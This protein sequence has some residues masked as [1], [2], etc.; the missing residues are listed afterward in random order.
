MLMFNRMMIRQK[1][2]AG[3]G[4]VLL[5]MA[6]VSTVVYLSISSISDASRWVNHTYDVIRNADSVNAAMVDMETG[7][8]GFMITGKDEYLEPYNSGKARFNELISK[9]KQL[10][11]DNPA[12][13]ERWNEVNELKSK[14]LEEVAE[15]EIAARRLVSQGAKANQHF[16]EVSSRTVGK[17]IFDSIRAMLAGLNSKFDSEGNTSGAQLVTLLTLDLVNMETGQRG[18]LLTGLDESLEPFNQGQQSLKGHIEQLRSGLA[19]SAVSAADVD[20]LQNRIAD[21][22]KQAAQ[23]EIDARREMSRFP[24]TIENISDMMA[25]GKG[26]LYMDQ[27]RQVLKDIVDAEEVLIVIRGETQ[28][29]ASQ[30]AKTVSIMGTFIAIAMGIV[31]AIVIAKGIVGPL[32]QA[33]VILGDIAKGEGD[34]TR[35]LVIH[36]HDEVGQLSNHFNAFMAKLESIIAEV[37]S[38]SNQLVKAAEEMT[39]VSHESSK[40]LNQQ[41]SETTQLAS[42]INQMAL[43]IEEVAHNTES[44]TLAAKNADNEAMSGNQ[45]V[46]E[47]LNSI[48]TLALDV[49]SAADVIDKL[50]L[51]S[52]SIGKV[53]D[54]IK[55]IADQTNLLALNAAIEA[56]RA[57]EQGRGF[58]VVADEVRTLAQRT[59]DSTSEIEVIISELQAGAEQAVNVMET[60]RVNSSTTLA[61]GEQTGKFLNSVTLAINTIL[62]LST[63]IATAAQEQS[64][65]TKE[66]SR[67]IVNIK[68]VAEETS[69]GA[70]QTR[71]TSQEV[72]KLSSNLQRLVAQFKV[73]AA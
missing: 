9:G 40:G 6:I 64:S 29:A 69:A 18:F 10:T 24:M 50:K 7:Q 28:L 5:L 68:N 13:V 15:P 8:R 4:L 46:V 12:Q 22:I 65:V 49:G 37:V 60:S 63:Q 42:A 48:K 44:A 23:P 73:Q 54:V 39:Q 34:L 21:W 45:L 59:Q 56:A 70:E 17:Q 36:S 71:I 26:K 66:V 14:W 41:N 20:A 25:Q 62:E 19:Y 35:R 52:E 57:G 27:T 67:N 55:G 16:K 30:T 58:A 31:I 38:S 51:Q 61:Q 1:I 72:A 2:F 53:L 47:T 11:S 32:R 33:N 43:T 3:Y